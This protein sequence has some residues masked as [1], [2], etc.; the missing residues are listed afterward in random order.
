MSF[1]RGPQVYETYIM[2]KIYT[3][4]GD[5]GDTSLFGGDRLSKSDSRIDCYGHLDELNAS[6]GIIVSTLK[7]EKLSSDIQD[8]FVFWQ[9]RLF[10]IGSHLACVNPQLKQRLPHL[11]ENWISLLESKIDL[12][13]AELPELKNFILPGGTLSAAHTHLARTICRRA[14]RSVVNLRKSDND[15]DLEFVV[16][17][18]NRFSDYLFVASR[19]LN[20]KMKQT[21][22][23]WVSK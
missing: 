11:D 9:S 1:D 13:Q 14:E 20:F 15:T 6:L 16:I 12:M 2:T 18:L 10:D 3:K 17:F 21:E 22:I 23:I 4:T 7:V 19:F 8:Q 5:H